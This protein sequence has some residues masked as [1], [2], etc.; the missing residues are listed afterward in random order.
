[1]AFDLLERVWGPRLYYGVRV[2]DQWR[3]GEVTSVHDWEN[4]Q[5]WICEVIGSKGNVWD[6]DSIDPRWF[7]NNSTFYF[8]N[9]EDR[10]MF[11]L[12]W[13]K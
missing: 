10:S 5:N 8:R 3:G 12:R 4:W 1:M 11:L 6:C 2:P 9:E 7:T 13:S